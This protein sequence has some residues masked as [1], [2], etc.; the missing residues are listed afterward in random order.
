MIVLCTIQLRTNSYNYHIKL[1]RHIEKHFKHTNIINSFVSLFLFRND[2]SIWF[3]SEIEWKH[4]ETNGRKHATTD[5]HRHT[6]IV[7]K[8]A[9]LS[10]HGSAG[11][12]L[13]RAIRR[14]DQKLERT[15]RYSRQTKHRWISFFV[16]SL[17]KF[18]RTQVQKLKSAFRAQRSFVLFWNILWWNRLFMN[19]R[20]QTIVKP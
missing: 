16:V 1:M 2:L 20:I 7:G 8:R 9:V 18:V 17:G 3:A 14:I 4:C 15:P 19:D 11:E 10:K 6:S 13:S 5:K 12:K